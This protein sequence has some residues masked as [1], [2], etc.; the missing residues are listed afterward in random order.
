V[1]ARPLEERVVV[2]TR[3]PDQAGELSELLRAAGARVVEVPTLVMVPVAG[4]EAARAKEAAA[5]AARGEYDAAL[6]TSKNAVVFFHDLVLA[7]GLSAARL[8]IVPLFAIGPA[9]ARALVERG[10]EPPVVA[11]EAVGEGLLATLRETLGERLEGKRVLFP[12]AREARDVV[13]EG[14]RSAGAEVDLVVLYETRA[15]TGGPGLPAGVAIDWVTFASPSAVRAFHQRFG[16]VRARVACIGPVTAKAVR[17]LGMEVGAMGAEHT[18]PGMVA[19][20]IEA[21]RR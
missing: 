2:V 15:V 8:G 11:G 10:Y 5:A 7:S 13:I 19:A 1:S 3:A 20:M 4:D 18:A 9:T 17:E 21:S 6:F 12:R 16:D 14:L